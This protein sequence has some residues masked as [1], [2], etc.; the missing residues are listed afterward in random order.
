MIYGGWEERPALNIE[1]EWERW[2]V[3]HQQNY[4]LT[5]KSHGAGAM[6]DCVSDS[7]REFRNYSAWRLAWIFVL[8]HFNFLFG[9][10][11]R[12]LVVLETADLQLAN[13]TRRLHQ[14]EF[15]INLSVLK[16]YIQKQ[17][18]ET[19][20]FLFLLKCIYTFLTKSR[21]NRQKYV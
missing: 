13:K 18:C 2:G 9:F 20:A 11:R 19:R 12:K 6:N 7:A 17:L 8:S 5:L 21:K 15:C 14:S 10:S 3:L 16:N 4:E 1:T